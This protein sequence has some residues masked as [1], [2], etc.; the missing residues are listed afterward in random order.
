MRTRAR[1]W[2][3]SAIGA[4]MA[5]AFTGIAQAG[6]PIENEH[7]DETS[8]HIE[9]EEH[10]GFCPDIPFLVLFEGH[11]KGSTLVVHHGDGFVYFGLRLRTSDTYTNVETG[12]SMSIEVVLSSKD[13][14]IVDNGDGTITITGQDVGRQRSYDDEG[15]LLF[16]DIGLIRYEVLVDTA[17]T[18]G[19][20]GDD[21]F[22]AFLGDTKVAGPHETLD[23][24]FCADLL[25]FIG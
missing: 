19:D 2:L 11:A 24:D 1:T 20:P 15:N 16:S 6:P 17:G 7:F 21:E 10:E 23:R 5:A 8:T 25:E 9:Q 14:K 12:R 13:Q 18:P 3:A 22:L 4:V